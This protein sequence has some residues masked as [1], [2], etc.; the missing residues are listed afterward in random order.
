[1]KDMCVP[2]TNCLLIAACRH[3]TY[4]TLLNQCTIL[5]ALLYVENIFGDDL[6][7]RRTLR[8]FDFDKLIQMVEATV[9]PIEWATKRSNRHPTETQIEIKHR[10][11]RASKII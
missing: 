11:E 2:C 8:R 7:Y 6:S 5:K 9:N 10:S 1:M 3:K 4:A